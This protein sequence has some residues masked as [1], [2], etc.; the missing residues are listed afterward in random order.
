MKLRKLALASA[1]PALL[2]ASTAAQASVRPGSAAFGASSDV[3]L[4]MTGERQSVAVA[5]ENDFN[6]KYTWVAALAAFL[7]GLGL[8]Y[9]LKDGNVSPD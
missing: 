6:R 7:A 2:L 1:V 9:A 4:A 5:S 3:A 8:Y